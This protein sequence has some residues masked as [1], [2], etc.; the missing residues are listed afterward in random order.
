MMTTTMMMTIT[1]KL[2]LKSFVLIFLLF[3]NFHFVKQSL[4]K[5]L[6]NIYIISIS[7]N[8]NSQY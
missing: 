4:T 7:E 1:N 6:T 8:F 3:L 5:T 2:K